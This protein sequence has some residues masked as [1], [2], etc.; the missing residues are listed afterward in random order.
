MDNLIPVKHEIK[1]FMLAGNCLFTV[2][3][4]AT[5][6]HFTYRV[7][8]PEEQ[9]NP[10]DPVHFVKVLSGPDNYSD[11]EMIGMLFSGCKYVHW[12]KSRF[13]ADCQS[14]KVFVWLVARL[15]QGALP[16]GV[17]VYHHGLCGRCGALLT[18]PESIERGL[19]PVCAT[20][21]F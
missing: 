2:A 4:R 17:E 18:T 5:G 21:A 10:Q 11:Y 3:N 20:K 12:R 13:G 7:Q 1:E 6:N 14:E 16:H 9:K 8:S 15:L 19:G